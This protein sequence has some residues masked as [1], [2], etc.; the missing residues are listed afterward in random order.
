MI[1]SAPATGIDRRRRRGHPVIVSAPWPPL[2][3]VGVAVAGERVVARPAACTFSTPGDRGEPR[4][5]LRPAQV[6][7]HR[8]RGAAIV[9]RVP[10]R[11]GSARQRHASMSASVVRQAVR[12]EVAGQLDDVGAVKHH[13]DPCR[14]RTS[15]AIASVSATVFACRRRAERPCRRPGPVMDGVVAVAAVETVS[16]PSPPGQDVRAVAAAEHVGIAVA[17]QRVAARPAGG[18]SRPRQSRRSRRRSASRRG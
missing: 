3:D 16:A 13:L 7:R 12:A 11:P 17:G 9:Q 4:R 2:S 10:S 14:R 6:D 5:A 8:H 15:R 1:V 18:R